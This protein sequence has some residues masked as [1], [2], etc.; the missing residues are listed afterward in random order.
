MK[1]NTLI[2]EMDAQAKVAAQA[3]A[4]AAHAKAVAAAARAVAKADDLLR[5]CGSHFLG[6][7]RLI[8]R[9]LAV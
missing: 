3:K 6:D 5:R 2:R 7:I 8:S 4:D 1:F 9:S